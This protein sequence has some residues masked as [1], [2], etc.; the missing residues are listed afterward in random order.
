Y[1]PYGGI[2]GYAL[3]PTGSTPT[4][5][6]LA[7]YGWDHP[8]HMSVGGRFIVGV[9]IDRDVGGTWMRFTLGGKA[10]PKSMWENRGFP[11]QPMYTIF[12][13]MGLGALF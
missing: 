2:G 7:T 5:L 13:R 6:I 1:Q 12:F 3:R 10:A 4:F 8:A 11:H 9:P